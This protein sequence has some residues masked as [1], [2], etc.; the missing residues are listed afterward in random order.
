MDHNTQTAIVLGMVFLPGVII[1]IGLGW[2]QQIAK[3]KAIDVL[4]T[5]AEKGE[6]PPAGVLE[7]V[8]QMSKPP[9]PAPVPPRRPTRGDHLSH[10]AGSAVLALGAAGIA[11]WRAPAPHARPEALM[12]IAL[13]V[14]VFF[15]AATAARL[16]A[17]HHARDEH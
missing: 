3:I 9:G 17:A 2:Q 13:I 7:A 8:T 16:V 11:W 6:E 5:Y 4:K 14:A 15:A 12:V 1:A 10:V